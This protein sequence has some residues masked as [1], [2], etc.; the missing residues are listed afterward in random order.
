MIVHL[1]CGIGNRIFAIMYMLHKYN[2]S[3][4]FVWEKMGE[5]NVQFNDLFNASALNLSIS[6]YSNSRTIQIHDWITK[7]D[8]KDFNLT[9]K[10]IR[11]KSNT[12]ACCTCGYPRCRK[13]IAK[14]IHPHHSLL[15]DLSTLKDKI[16]TTGYTLHIRNDK[17]RY[18]HRTLRKHMK[19]FL[20][21]KNYTYIAVERNED[22]NFLKR[23]N[24]ST[25]LQ[26]NIR[27]VQRGR[28]NMKSL[29]SS[30]FDIYALSFGNVISTRF[31]STF[32][33]LSDCFRQ[34]RELS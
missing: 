13:D 17:H 1:G 23:I 2:N 25:I 4:H 34:V 29:L 33:R 26:D 8:L 19:K 32:S 28:S 18:T 16:N 15:H 5:E 14:Y 24:I 30:V 10:Q 7:D 3:V 22:V 9:G 11:K 27:H 31:R 6:T 20:K 21:L 12:I